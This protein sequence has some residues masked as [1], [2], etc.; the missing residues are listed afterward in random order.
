MVIRGILLG[1]VLASGTAYAQRGAGG[2]VPAVSAPLARAWSRDSTFTVWLFVRPGIALSQAV[3]R[4]TATGAQVRHTSRW[5][6]AV[7]VTG[8]TSA[9]RVL[10]QDPSLRRIQLL[11][12][13][14][15]RPGPDPTAP[16]R[17]AI[18]L[19]PDTCGA[20]G[21]PTYGPSE[22]PYRRLDL[23][24]LADHGVDGTGVRIAILDAG[25]NTLNPA[26]AGVT[27][28]AQH[29]FVFGD[30]VVRNQPDDSL[31]LDPQFH[32]T[33][34]WSLFAGDVSGR[35]VG[36]AR[37]ASYLLAKTEDVRSETRIEEDNYVAAL[38]WADSIG[39]D[40]VSSSLGYLTFDNGFSYTPSQLNGDV[41]V[42]SV[43]AESASAHGILVVTAAGNTGPGFRTL[44]TP[45]DAKSVITAGAEDSLGTIASFSSRGPTADG[46]LKPDLTAPGVA[47]CTVTGTGTLGRL[48]GTSFATPILAASAAL[49]KEEQP[50]LGPLA[51]RAALRRYAANAAQP[52][53]TRGWGRPDVTASAVFPNGVTPLSPLPPR[54]ASVTPP[55]SWTAGTTPGFAGPVAYRLRIARDSLL[56]NPIVDSLMGT[57]TQYLP[58]RAFKP[59]APVYWR[60]DATAMGVTATTGVVGPITVPPWATLV[61]F[62]DSA[63]V[64]TDSVQPTFIWT[65]PGVAAPPGPFRFDLQVF[66]VDQ[67]LPF[68]G[69]A[70]LT[71]T[72]FRIPTAL[73][74][75]TAY[76]WTL[77]VHAGSDT[78]RVSSVGVLLVLDASV[79][80]ATL[81]FQ[82][83]PNPFPAVGRDST[84][85]WFDLA[86]PGETELQ[87]LDLRGGVVR[88]IIPNGSLAGV[89]TPGRYG[90]GPLGGSTCDPQV[91]WDGRA[92]D[93]R[94][95]PAGV[96]ILRLRSGTTQLY[97]RLVFMG[98]RH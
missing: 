64:T 94:F 34:V 86:T 97:K 68:Y 54:L 15:V 77:V 83:F 69:A 79:P 39:V 2:A 31:L 93:G 85:I 48:N 91:T 1:T 84:C 55:F 5:L 19:A 57:A 53:S 18:V 38:E 65:V 90:R 29:D 22:M 43:A 40:I 75:G 76:R 62:N 80:R 6:H 28:T 20:A 52:D 63:G 14:R 82:N 11:G 37:G 33:A 78:T 17:P 67:G 21:D 66:R 23:R 74:M 12:R 89:L 87:V 95:V 7:S 36:I 81:L 26:F 32:G 72:S 51:L 16:P 46:R 27:V 49:L 88:R 61:T 92:D 45:G 3:T 24:G 47:V 9:L 10:S 58:G 25:F 50:T 41:A 8:S 13:W 44:V 98:P 4:I 42:T 73:E 35:L 30:S 56:A 59:G 60:V 96:Y 71:D 70:G